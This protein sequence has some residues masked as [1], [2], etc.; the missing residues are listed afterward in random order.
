LQELAVSVGRIGVLLLLFSPAQSILARQGCTVSLRK[1][2]GYMS[3]RVAAGFFVVVLIFTLSAP[4]FA[5]GAAKEAR[6]EGRIVRSNKDK[7]TI[8]VRIGGPSAEKTVHYDAS[9]NWTSQ[10]RGDKKVNTIDASEV[11]DGDY[12]ICVGAEDDKGEFHAATIS[13]RLSH[14]N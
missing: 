9:T 1:G 5:Q 8:T 2:G 11:K 4:K 7:S 12:V 10:F 3:H 6:V 13:K 14:S